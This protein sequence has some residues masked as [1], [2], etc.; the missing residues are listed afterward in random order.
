MKSS[1]S[2]PSNS[3][4]GRFS[5]RRKSEAVLRV[6][7]GELIDAVSREIGVTAATLSQ[8]REEFIQGGEQNLKSRGPA[9]VDDREAQLKA[10]IGDQA[11]HIEFLRRALKKVGVVDFP[12][13]TSTNSRK[14]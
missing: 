2:D 6:L 9:T 12:Q 11:V 5:A 7:R 3:T 1:K 10:M 8:W 13:G 4:K 14:G